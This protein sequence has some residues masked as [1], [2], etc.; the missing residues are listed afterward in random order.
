MS[1]AVPY[2][3]DDII[4]QHDAAKYMLKRRLITRAEY[5]RTIRA[6]NDEQ[7]RR[8]LAERLRLLALRAAQ[9]EAR[10]A[11]K[12]KAYNAKRKERKCALFA[13]YEIR[14]PAKDGTY[15]VIHQDQR[16]AVG[17]FS[18]TSTKQLKQMLAERE[19]QVRQNHEQDDY[20]SSNVKILLRFSHEI[21][22]VHKENI[23]INK[24]PMKGAFTLRR[25][26]LRYSEGI[27]ET[28]FQDL[29]GQCV[30][31]LLISLLGS[32]W[33]TVNKQQL[34]EYFQTAVRAKGDDYLK[35]EPFNG[36]FTVDSGVNVDMLKY[37]CEK[38]Q[39]SLYGFDA[40][41]NCFVKKISERKSD[42]RPICFYH[43]D[44]HMYL[45]T[46]AVEVKS[47][48]SSREEKTTVV[49][50][51]LEMD[52]KVKPA[53]REYVEVDCF[54]NALL[55]ENKIVYLKQRH[56]TADVIRYI[57]NTHIQPK[58]KVRNQRIT[59]VVL[60]DKN[61]T[62]ICDPNEDDYTWK[63]I[64]FICD[65]AGLPFQNQQI[66]GLIRTLAKKFFKGERRVLTDDEKQDIVAEQKQLC[67]LCER[68][69]TQ[70]EYDHAIPL[71]AGG[72]NELEN[73]QALCVPCHLQKTKEENEAGDFIKY[74]P[75]A[76]TFNASALEII[77]S[78]HFKQWAFVERLRK[79]MPS[80]P[81]HKLDHA[82]CRRNLVM[83]GEYPFPKFSV[84]DSPT[85]YDGSD[86]KCGLY[87]VE[88]ENYFPFRGNGWYNYA[89]VKEAL[90]LNIIQ[91]HNLTHQFLSS[92]QLPADYF[93]QFAEYLVETTREK[94]LDKLIV[95]SMVGCWAI[96]RST[97]ES[98]RFDADKHRASTALIQ[99]GTFVQS[100][101]INGTPLY[102]IHE[103]KEIQKDDMFLPL[104]HQIMSMEAMG[105]YKLEQLI[106]K[107]GG[108][109]L[110]RNTD[111]ILYQ[112]PMI[113]ISS[114]TYSDGTTLK[115]RYDDIKPL[116]V[117]EVCRFSRSGSYNMPRMEY[118]DFVEQN[119]FQA[120]AQQIYDSN[121]GCFVSGFAGVGKTVFSNTL[122][123][124]IE[125]QGK[126]C[127]KLAPTRK[128]ASHI[129]GKTIHKFYMN[130]A[131]SNNYEKKILQSL[132]HT[133]Y[134][135]VDE[136]SMVKEVF[137]RFFTMLKR[138]APQ[139]KF[140]I[141]G[142][143]DQ[144]PPVN[145]EYKG[146]YSESWALYHLC[147]GQRLQLKTCR[148]SDD[149]VF[150]LYNDVRLGM[151]NI[152]V[153]QFKP[154][155]LNRLNIAY[156]HETRKRVNAL[157]MERFRDG[158]PFLTCEANHLNPK[159]QKAQIYEGMPIV[160]FKNDSR[161]GLENSAMYT[162]RSIDQD[163]GTFSIEV[164]EPEVR[165]G[166]GNKK[167]TEVTSNG[168]THILTLDASQF[169]HHFYPGFC[170]TVHVSQGCSFDEPYTIY[171][172]NMR[173]MDKKAKYVALSRARQF[174]YIHIVG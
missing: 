61:L 98:M 141:V 4:F 54:T 67:T 116:K 147:D 102:A 32:Y 79:E 62:I 52:Q 156:S 77:Q 75:V 154:T 146:N 144:L 103:K 55:L 170:I 19:Q 143:Y 96:N 112:G 65:K 172:W 162:I 169:K 104:Y 120:V 105:L 29:K 56:I 168:D 12:R 53:D 99:E 136:I 153:S 60:K 171:D 163:A 35:G 93:K 69:T 152:D 92:F 95:N 148:R 101:N 39:I 76:S 127:I 110:E 43:I 82:K 138:Y 85:E 126:K 91:T 132:Q 20:Y 174:E 8:D 21:S 24:V 125:S 9:A 81:I 167:K 111:A 118:H 94:N 129:G 155:A 2:T 80:V 38:K 40:Q 151:D 59:E 108:V 87:F 27:A 117:E 122:I 100:F 14:K 10:K 150:H 34:F 113:D 50:S 74:D 86:I 30:Y 139:L 45:I 165:K 134:I 68:S 130:L 3:F 83:Y 114:I 48:A 131:L 22:A 78:Q 159:T 73:F 166:S 7:D 28:S 88:T 145:D 123:Q 17:E 37:L 44:G 46:G 106:I 33:K 158:R 11:E 71:N 15:Q 119:D 36:K 25:D 89:M 57:C 107:N 63:D 6:L 140:I 149:K 58:V 66:G 121:M 124:L 173:Y 157:C 70:W 31:E 16:E 13:H 84:M 64:K 1:R 135:F 41:D 161:K 160:A 51:L 18:F 133:D 26:W 115:Y 142:D 137:Y 90:E 164:A 42:Y 47:I 23:N 109:P 49:S 97:F 5:N 72:S 128:A